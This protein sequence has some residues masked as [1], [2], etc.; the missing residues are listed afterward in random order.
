M[1]CAGGRC[2]YYDK[3]I[4]FPLV[5]GPTVRERRVVDNIVVSPIVMKN[6]MN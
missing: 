4:A 6:V 1:G 3:L 2:K 5:L